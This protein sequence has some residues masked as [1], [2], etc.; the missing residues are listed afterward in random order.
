[1]INHLVMALMFF[2]FVIAVYG[3]CYAVLMLL[4]FVLECICTN[5]SDRVA[6]ILSVLVLLIIVFLFCFGLTFV[7][8]LLSSSKEL[9]L[10][11]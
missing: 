9:V 7:P 10:L 1:M 11:G 2:G 5:F 6:N 4:C 3:T 8:L